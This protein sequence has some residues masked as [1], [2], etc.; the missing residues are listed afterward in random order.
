MIDLHCHLLPGVDDGPP[1]LETSLALARAAAA[2]GTRTI[3][4]TP[5]IDTRWGVDPEGVPAAVDRIRD[6]LR[7]AHIELDVRPGGEVSLTRMADLTPAAL[8]AVRLGGGPYL[9]IESPHRDSGGAGFKAAA[10][11]LLRRGERIVL[12]HPERCPGFQRRPDD[13]RRLVDAGI[14]CSITSSALLGRFGATV[15][16]FALRLLREGLVHNVASDAHEPRRRGPELLAG[17]QAAERHLPG[18]LGQ[19]DWLTRAVP[20]AVLAGTPLPSRPEL[21]ARRSS[22]R[23]WLGR[24][25]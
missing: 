12:A 19:A 4:A 7:D 3:V 11:Q 17:L 2:A 16:T 24:R 13:V 20:E 8:D 10:A 25:G 21:P 22:L 23:R 6:A 5:H 14:V 18:L 9:L 15:Q 1:D